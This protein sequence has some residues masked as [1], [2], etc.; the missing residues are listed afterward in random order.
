MKQARYP[1]FARIGTLGLFLF[2]YVNGK[3]MGYRAETLSELH[4]RIR[5]ILV[6]I[7]RQTLNALLLES[8]EGLQKCVQVDGEYA[9]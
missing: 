8:M 7:P 6:E 5:V 2:S 4:V 3:L 1:L 9:G